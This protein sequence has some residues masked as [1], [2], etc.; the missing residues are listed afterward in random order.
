MYKRGIQSEVVKKYWQMF[1]E[2]GK[3]RRLPMV[4]A[5]LRRLVDLTYST[6]WS[7]FNQLTSNCTLEDYGW[8]YRNYLGRMLDVLFFAVYLS[9][10]GVFGGMQEHIFEEGFLRSHQTLIGILSVFLLLSVLNWL[11]H[12]TLRELRRRYDWGQLWQKVSLNLNE[13]ENEEY[14]GESFTTRSKAMD[15]I[16]GTVSED[17]FPLRS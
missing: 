6:D 9:L 16:E 5:E 10:I 3:R 4:L 17:V 15:R 14:G 2:Y 1:H 12:L 13:F 7:I 11:L 8:G